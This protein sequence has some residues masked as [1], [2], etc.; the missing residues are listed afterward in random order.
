MRSCDGLV[1]LL[2]RSKSP[3]ERAEAA[4]ALA[5][6]PMTPKAWISALSA[7]PLL[8]QLTMQHPGGTAAVCLQAKR[9]L[10]SITR[11][12]FFH[13][14]GQVEATSASILPGFISLLH[15]NA[16]VLQSAAA[17]TLKTLASNVH[18]RGHIVDAGA[19]P[20]LVQ[21]LRRE[22]AVV[23][24]TA[25][26]ALS[27]LSFE[28]S[29]L[30]RLIS[31]GAVAPLVHLL[32]SKTEEVRC[33]VAFT[34]VNITT[35]SAH[36]QARALAAGAISPL[37][38]LMKSKSATA[39]ETA[40]QVLGN[41]SS[42]S[43]AG[44]AETLPNMLAAG[45][46]VPIVAFLQDSGCLPF[47]PLLSALALCANLSSVA[48]CRLP[49]VTAGA[50]PHLVRLL[51]SSSSGRLEH[52][53][54]SA[55]D[56]LACEE[57]AF[58]HQIIAAGAVGPLMKL[59]TATGTSDAVQ[60]PAASALGK[61]SNGHAEVSA[62]LV[63]SGAVAHFV[64]L[65][66]CK[67]AKVQEKAITVLFALFYVG[68]QQA[69]KDLAAA[70][71]IP[72]LIQL[73][74]S[75]SAR[76]QQYAVPLLHA[77]AEEGSPA[78]LVAMRTAGLLPILANRRRGSPNNVTD[79]GLESSLQQMLGS[80]NTL[81]VNDKDSVGGI[82]F[83]P[84]LS[85]TSS[86]VPSASALPSETPS[87][88]PSRRGAKLCWTCGV[89]DVPLKK[90]SVCTVAAYCGAACQKADWKVHK[91]QCTGLKASAAAATRHD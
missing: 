34:L 42:Q 76:A 15:N 89:V 62:K 53:A 6:L 83:T 25:A 40:V 13:P 39:R 36:G 48:A 22:S 63:S 81:S 87:L 37:V 2:L 44:S 91:G 9:A 38:K 29:A 90:C 7:I 80:N 70:G 33:S 59:L 18:N 64:Q 19:I 72:P 54:A 12:A 52:L 4:S 26:R 45:A 46:I 35:G 86:A 51:A 17:F 14:A 21:L 71:G 16:E 31:A 88:Q 5:D 23:H 47:V 1:Q 79:E 43:A 57:A 50:V 55:L 84:V 56:N 28:P 61:L 69:S 49:L 78:D 68:N 3:A 27:T 8:A 20:P 32:N 58:R 67:S 82:P 73:L 75:G 65:L 66:R 77:V 11:Y 60:V 85:S 30:A 41:L 10:I 24:Q 74:Q